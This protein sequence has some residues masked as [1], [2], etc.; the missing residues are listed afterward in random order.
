MGKKGVEEMISE[1]GIFIDKCKY[2]PFSSNNIIVP[3]DELERM[4]NELKLRLPSEFERSKK[5]MRNKESILAAARTRSDAIISESVNEA[6]RLVEENRITQ[7]ANDRAEEILASARDEADR[8]VNDANAEATEVR[9]GA[10]NYTKDKIDEMRAFLAASLEA[11]RENYRNLVETLEDQVFS[12]ENNMADVDSSISYIT[13]EPMAKPVQSS[14]PAP[15][16]EYDD[17]YDDEEDV[18][19]NYD[20]EEEDDDFDDDDDYDDEDDDDFLD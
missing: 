1:I 14:Q 5:I 11:D 8:I 15:A 6:N 7:M 4:L 9:L 13:G 2:Q 12:L 3:R 20:D 16:D 18:D 17:E 19:D 10:L